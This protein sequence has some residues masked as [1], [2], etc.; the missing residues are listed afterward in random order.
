V[1]LDYDD[2]V[3]DRI[4]NADA[5]N[6][7]L[8][9]GPLDGRE[10]QVEPGTDELVVVMHDGARYLYDASGR[11]ELRPD[12]RVLPVFEYRGREYPLR[13]PQS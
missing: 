4:L 1:V 2:R 12:G 5:G 8:A 6:A 7:V 13:S 3:Q 10:H 9:G 11:V